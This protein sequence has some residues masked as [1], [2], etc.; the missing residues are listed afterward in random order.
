M[1]LSVASQIEG[2]G[3]CC[4]K[5]KTLLKKWYS[6]SLNPPSYLNSSAPDSGLVKTVQPDP[7]IT[8]LGSFFGCK[9]Q[10]KQTGPSVFS[11]ALCYC[12]KIHVGFHMGNQTAKGRGLFI[13]CRNATECFLFPFKQLLFISWLRIENV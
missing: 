1:S 6:K 8:P 11:S 9:L 7:V 4:Q 5:G 12:S 2:L 10:F 13:I 3:D